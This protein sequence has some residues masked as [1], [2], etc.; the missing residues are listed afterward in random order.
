M[1]RYRIRASFA[2]RYEIVIEAED[3]D[4]AHDIAW[5]CSMAECDQD[6]NPW[7]DI[8]FQSYQI[9]SVDEIKEKEDE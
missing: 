9:E 8:D 1:P 5:E 7:N 6:G 3:E 2:T 4:E